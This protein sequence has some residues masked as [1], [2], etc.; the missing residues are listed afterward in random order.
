MDGVRLGGV[1]A[2]GPVDTD[3][4]LIY[5][6]RRRKEA[7]RF[8]SYMF[9]HVGYVDGTFRLRRIF[10]LPIVMCLILVLIGDSM[11]RAQI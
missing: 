1:T 8:L 10:V 9:V 3:S 6:P 2:S 7:W 4:V 5:N 11:H